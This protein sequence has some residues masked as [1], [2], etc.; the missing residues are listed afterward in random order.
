MTVQNKKD[1]LRHDTTS[2][3]SFRLPENLVDEI[4]TEAQ[5]NEVTPNVLV[6][7][8]LERYTRWD[9][10][11]TKAGFIPVTKVL[12]RELIE[13]LQ[14]KELEEVAELVERKEFADI[15]LL[16]RNEFDIDSF[17]DIIKMR[18]EVSGY[19][20]R[21]TV[22]QNTHTC[23]IQ[24]DLGAKWSIY[25]SARYKA[26]LEDLGIPS[27]EFRSSPNTIQFDVTLPKP[28]KHGP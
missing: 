20:Y 23:T 9:S 13:R 15:S 18:A 24:H 10:T 8:I 1:A 14:D 28:K 2:S 7:N 3:I 16:M 26:A 12:L 21:H 4:K 19:P 11:A 27:F 6:S 5:L 22:K 17:L 25:L